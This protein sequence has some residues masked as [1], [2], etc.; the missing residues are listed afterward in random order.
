MKFNKFGMADT[1]CSAG[2]HTDV[3]IR[4]CMHTACPYPEHRYCNTCRKYIGT[5][6][7]GVTID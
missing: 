3:T 6:V 2:N 5:K 7:D 1:D 4:P